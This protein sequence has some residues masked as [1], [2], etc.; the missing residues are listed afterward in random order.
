M[1]GGNGGG[2]RLFVAVAREP[3]ATT[4]GPTLRIT[5]DRFTRETFCG[6]HA[7]GQ[8]FASSFALVNSDDFFHHFGGQVIGSLPA[9]DESENKI[10]DDNTDASS[11]HV[12]SK[13][14][15]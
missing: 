9:D 12:E 1:I 4:L 2:V 6:R 14:I 10:G 3:N 7:L 11:P 13:S 8:S 15:P 5:S